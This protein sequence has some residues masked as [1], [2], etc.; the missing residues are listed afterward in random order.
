VIPLTAAELAA[1]TGGNLCGADGPTAADEPTPVPVVTSVV[2]D[3][4]AA[5]AGALFAALPGEQVDGHEFAADAAGRGAALVLG[6]RPVPSAGIP[7]LVV[8]DVT[9]ALAQIAAE[10]IRRCPGLWVVG[11]TGSVGKTTAKDLIAAV[12]ESGGAR[13][14]SAVGSFNN[15]LGVPLTICRC[16]ADT[17]ALVLEMGARGIGHVARLCGIADP[18]VGVVLNVGTAHIGEF[19]SRAAIAEAKGELAEAAREVA[20]LNAD[21]PLVR[22]MAS[23]TR[24]RVVLIGTSADAEVRAQDVQTDATGRASFLLVTPEGEVPVRLELIGEHQVAN[25]LAAAAVGRERG[26]S[27][28]DIAA[29][30]GTAGPRSRWRMEATERSDG[31]L[32]LNDAYNANPDSVRAALKTLVGIGR[33]GGRRTWAVLGEMAELGDSSAVEHDTIGRLAVRLDVA[34]LVVVGPAAGALHAGAVLEGSWG[35]ESVHVP[36]TDAAVQLLTNELEPGDVVLVKASRVAG[37]ERVAAALLDP[38][39]ADSSVSTGTSAAGRDRP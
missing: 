21:D 15:D 12:L 18:A 8:T 20:V 34:R 9:V 36:D 37:L 33:D 32:V 14:V 11:V 22:A 24:G 2:I 28:P 16:D 4:R 7:T 25:A 38:T 19:G 10:V 30:L 3:S 23:R 35:S 27:L 31:V 1:L 39:V 6:S 29:A 17:E 5:T 26:L 13:V